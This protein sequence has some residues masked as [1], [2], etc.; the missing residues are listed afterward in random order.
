MLRR[1]RLATRL[2]CLALLC[3]LM[4]CGAGDADSQAV[5]NSP[6]AVAS[7]VGAA[8]AT[9]PA[10]QGVRHVVYSH[11]GV[12]S[13]TVDGVLWLAKPRLADDSGNPPPGWDENDTAGLFRLTDTDHAVFTAD[14]GVQANFTKAAAGVTDPTADCE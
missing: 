5:R 12:V 14:S 13:T 2:L 3:G 1:M 11:C 10:Q 8:S 7:P 6:A 4:A 9:P